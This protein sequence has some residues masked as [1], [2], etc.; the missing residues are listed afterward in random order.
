MAKGWNCLEDVNA[1]HGELL[2]QGILCFFSHAL[3]ASPIACF[4]FR[5]STH[6]FTRASLE[7]KSQH[8]RKGALCIE[9]AH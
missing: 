9:A 5:L 8:Y 2:A 7:G 6:S 3:P 1:F 4:L